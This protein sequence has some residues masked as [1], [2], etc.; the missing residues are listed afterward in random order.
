MTRYASVVLPLIAFAAPALAGTINISPVGG[1]VSLQSGPLASTVFGGPAPAWSTSSLQSVH[2]SLASSGINTNG[3]VTILAADTSNGLALLTLVD[4]ETGVAGGNPT[5]NLFMQ[6]T[7]H[8]SN[9]GY[10]NDPD[11]GITISPPGGNSRIAEGQF[12]WD[13]ST[14]GDGFGWSNLAIGNVLTFRFNLP[15]KGALGLNM[16]ETFQFVTWTGTSWA[17]VTIPAFQSSFSINGEFGFAA[18]VIPL[19]GAA[20]LAMAPLGILPLVRRRRK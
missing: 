16:S 15:S 19:P 18:V 8:G 17:V 13:S 4:R 10:V 3:R 12:R 11:E 6:S 2:A 7:A 1:G 20:M 14:S 5:G 9:I